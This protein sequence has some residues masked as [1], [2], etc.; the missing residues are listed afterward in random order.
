M[1]VTFD[2][3]SDE[4][5]RRKDFDALFAM[6]DGEMILATLKPKGVLSVFYKASPSLPSDTRTL[7]RRL[8]DHQIFSSEKMG[9]FFTTGANYKFRELC[10]T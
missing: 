2:Y 1:K 9:W 3:G 5:A 4:S 6:P 10:Q 8:N 7:W